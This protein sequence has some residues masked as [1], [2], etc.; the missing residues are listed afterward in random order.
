MLRL[1]PRSYGI[2]T[3]TPNLHRKRSLAKAWARDR[4]LRWIFAGATHLLA[5]GTPGVNTL[6]QMGASQS[7]LVN[8]PF[9][10]DLSAYKR[11]N[12]EIEEK[13]RIVRFLSVG[14]LDNFYKGHDL[15]I[16]ALA[17]ASTRCSTPFQYYIAGSGTDQERLRLLV[18]ELDLE[19]TVQFVGWLEPD[20]LRCLY[21]ASDVLIHPSPTH[22]PFPNAILEAMAASL[23]VLGSDM[24]GSAV[25]RIQHGINGF[26]HPAGDVHE[27]SEQITFLL[28]DRDRIRE[29][30]RR[31]RSTAEQWPLERAVTTIQKLASEEFIH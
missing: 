15:A 16:R 6:V 2:W 30:G 7:R 14:R 3:D 31:A 9:Y 21:R 4:W 1:L 11:E 13:D 20:D 22:D 18:K 12:A 17:K 29:I 8:F 28:H 25:D 27:L 5:T 23:V 26:L 24:S 10:I 19:K